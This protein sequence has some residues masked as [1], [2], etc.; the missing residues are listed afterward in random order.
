M[1]SMAPPT[2]RQRLVTPR[3]STKREAGI[4]EATKT[5]MDRRVKRPLSPRS[6]GSEQERYG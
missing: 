4:G 2:V 5:T 1:C 3:G 6:M